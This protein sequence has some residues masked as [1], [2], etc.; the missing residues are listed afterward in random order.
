MRVPAAAIGLCYPLSGIQRFT[1]CLGVSVTKRILVASEEF[2]SAALQEIGFLD[3]LVSSKQELDIYAR[4]YAQNIAD[5]APLSVQSM[6]RILRQAAAGSVD[7]A[8]AQELTTVCLESNDLKEGFLAKQEKR[9]P[10]FEG[11]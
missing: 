4:D 11:R 10:V 8:W 3:H 5:L 1:Q 2:C 6:K 7:P 9:K